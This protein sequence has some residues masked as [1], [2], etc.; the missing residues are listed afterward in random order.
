MKGTLTAIWPREALQVATMRERTREVGF[1]F[2]D[3]REVEGKR[4]K[5]GARGRGLGDVP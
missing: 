5:S 1:K 3:R 4:G 2:E